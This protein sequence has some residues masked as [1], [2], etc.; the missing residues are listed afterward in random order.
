M[1]ITA[2]RPRGS[3]AIPTSSLADIAF[4]LLVFFLVTTVFDEEK[5]LSLVLPEAGRDVPVVPSNLL[6][7]AVQ[8]DGVV[9]VRRGAGAHVQRILAAD[10]PSVWRTE[11]ADAPGLVAVVSTAPDAPYGAMIDVLDALQSAGAERIS[12]GLL[13]DGRTR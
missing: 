1:T 3:A 9:Q 10:V 11:V 13:A 4:L 12:L 6:H 5:G 7:L 8:P 2:R